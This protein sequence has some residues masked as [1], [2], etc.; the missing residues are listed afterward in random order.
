MTRS[1]RGLAALAVVV[2]AVVALLVGRAA[3]TLAAAPQARAA[4][5]GAAKPSAFSLQRRRSFALNG[6]TVHCP[7]RGFV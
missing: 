3:L 4:E 6:K 2:F 7:R 5:G 1:I